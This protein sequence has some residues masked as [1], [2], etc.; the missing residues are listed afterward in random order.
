MCRWIWELRGDLQGDDGLAVASFGA[1]EK[2]VGRIEFLRVVGAIGDLAPEP[3]Y[4][5]LGDAVGGA[6]VFDAEVDGAAV[7]IEEG[8]NGVEEVARQAVAGGLEFDMQ[9]LAGGGG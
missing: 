9:A 1:R 8:A 4:G 5:L 6:V 7:G 2:Q 3:G